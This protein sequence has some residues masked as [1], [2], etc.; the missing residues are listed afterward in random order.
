[1]V[2]KWPPKEPWGERSLLRS[3]N[4]SESSKK[5]HAQVTRREA[6][7]PLGKVISATWR[8]TQVG[9]GWVQKPETLRFTTI[10]EWGHLGESDQVSGV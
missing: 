4:N 8:I 7:L 6:R 1:M 3:G 2:R 9:G 5:P 10:M